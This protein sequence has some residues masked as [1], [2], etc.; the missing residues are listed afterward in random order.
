ML[1]RGLTSHKEFTSHVLANGPSAFPASAPA[2]TTHQTQ[3]AFARQGLQPPAGELSPAPGSS[4]LT[5]GVHGAE[6]RCLTMPFPTT[7]PAGPL[8]L[9]AGGHFVRSLRLGCCSRAGEKGR[10]RRRSE[11]TR[12]LPARVIPASQEGP[13]LYRGTFCATACPR[14]TRSK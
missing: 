5:P 9:V 3:G 6:T 10:A 2:S 4:Q 7:W 14:E 1:C 13:G 12:P 8:S 11:G